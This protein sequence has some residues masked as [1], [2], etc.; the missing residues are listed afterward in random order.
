[1]ASY[2]L[3][4]HDT[5]MSS[6]KPTVQTILFEQRKIRQY[7]D[8]LNSYIARKAPESVFDVWR[9]FVKQSDTK[10]QAMLVTCINDNLYNLVVTMKDLRTLGE[11]IDNIEGDVVALKDEVVEAR[12]AVSAVMDVLPDRAKEIVDVI[13]GRA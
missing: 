6:P 7:S 2:T 13:E 4:S 10:L 3:S 12:D 1:V 8:D 9:N 11:V 5:T